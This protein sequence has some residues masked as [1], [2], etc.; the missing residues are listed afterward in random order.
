M[1]TAA[2]LVAG[3]PTD[4]A[5]IDAVTIE[6][7][8]IFQMPMALTLDA[9]LPEDRFRGARAALA[10]AKAVGEEHTGVHVATATVRARGVGQAIVEEAR[11]RGVEAIVLG[12]EKPSRIRGGARFGGRGGL[13]SYAGDVVRYVVARAP[14]RV[15]VTAPPV[16]S[17]AAGDGSDPDRP[18]GLRPTAGAGIV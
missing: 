4:E 13:E 18:G 11:R 17:E 2:L 5:A 1:R 3:E 9:R 8:W 14:C 10:R 16:H 6:A 7:V 15:I 12:A